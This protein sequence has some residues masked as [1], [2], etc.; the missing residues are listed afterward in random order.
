[1]SIKSQKTILNIFFFAFALIALSACSGGSS[2][3]GSAAPACDPATH[4]CDTTGIAK[5]GC[6]IATHDCETGALL[7]DT[8]TMMPPSPPAACEAINFC[9]ERVASVDTADPSNAGAD[10]IFVTAPAAGEAMAV[11]VTTDY[12]AY[13]PYTYSGAA[14][15][16][17]AANQERYTA[18]MDG[19]TVDQA[20]AKIQADAEYSRV[21]T[22]QDGI[23]LIGTAYAHARGYTG[24]R[25][26]TP[27][28]IVIAN[29]GRGI[30]VTSSTPE[31]NGDPISSVIE[32]ETPDLT[33]EGSV[34]ETRVGNLVTTVT[35]KKNPRKDMTRTTR[36]TRRQSLI[37]GYTANDPD[38]I[39]TPGACVICAT[40]G[41]VE[42]DDSSLVGIMSAQPGDGL[43][44]I[45]FD[46]S[47]KPVNI[48]AGDIY[49]AATPAN[50]AS[51]VLAIRE[52]SGA[53]AN[54]AECAAITDMAMKT[55]S[56]DCATI[57]VMNN[58]WDVASAITPDASFGVAVTVVNDINVEETHNFYYKLAN[59]MS[60]ISDVE[61]A[62]WVEAVET[63][64]VVFGAGDY[65]HNSENGIATLYED[66]NFETVARSVVTLTNSDAGFNDHMN[67]D[68][69]S[70]VGEMKDGIAWNLLDAENKNRASSHARL[71][72]EVASLK[73]KWLTV[74]AVNEPIDAGSG[75][76]TVNIAPFSNG[77]G[78]AMAWCLAAPGVDITTITAG[79]NLHKQ[80]SGTGI[81]AAH[82][83]GAIAVLKGAFDHLTPEQLVSV[84]LNTAD[85]LGTAGV[86]EVYGHG[87]LNLAAAIDPLG[88]AK[89]TDPS[90]KPIAR[91]ITLD[92]SGITLPTSFGES[93]DGFTVG[94]IDDYKRAY[95]GNPARIT[96]T[97]AAFTLGDTLATWDSPE[98]Q[99][100]QLDSNSKMQF[101]NYDESEHAK[102]T[103]IFTHH[104]PN[105][106]IAF[107][108][109]EEHKTPDL[110]LAGAGEELHFQK[111]RPIA[112][113]LMQVNSTHKLG[114]NLTVKNAITTGEFDTGNRFNEAMANLNYTS[115]NHQLTIGA[116][117]LQEYGQFLGASGTGAYQ[118]SD[119]TSSQIT[120]LAVTQNLPLNSAI[121]LKYTGFKTEV[122]MRY[123]NFATINDLTANEYQ[124][125]LTKKQLFGKSDSLNIELIQPF[126]VTDGKLQ[127]ST[128][129]GYN[130]DGD[131]NNVTQNYS[132][133]PTNRRQQIRMTWQNQLNHK[134][135]T[136]LFIS[137]Q[138]E[139][140]VNKPARQ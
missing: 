36:E 6:N 82:V 69:F 34:T 55:A 9:G 86:D 87:L 19:D 57:T 64:V 16:T 62:A 32:S 110:R 10:F 54:V 37:T 134:T 77:C 133:K 68:R 59:K 89:I 97:N 119:A 22:G 138:Y 47:I 74:V 106:T 58:G 109:N 120:H 116:G 114:K 53:D 20:V 29:L 100:I 1:M 88:E 13:V 78:D 31:L 21:D 92:N 42:K 33:V 76:M 8:D 115:E 26:T 111:I 136:K 23:D 90:L 129:L 107:S 94:F 108:Y 27:N 25:G 70:P 43:Q 81:A 40:R 14:A 125:S 49:K 67:K 123:D 61:A 65:G 15:D 132:L 99:S 98:L 30:G 117:S 118:L 63:T 85:D 71:P 28:S 3:G 72:L 44:G 93:L 124:L 60:T 24:K 80:R 113:D 35:V 95:I 12:Q 131:Y 127:Q 46:A 91:G 4:F 103:L 122:D 41:Q 105:H 121:K 96:R 104:L 135:K 39:V 50:R 52:A 102:D 66:E 11:D 83:S 101:S 5:A 79:N 51:L 17:Q 75:K 128:V 38:N 84:I 126:A 7:P 73:G 48:F 2:G 130:A 140:H 137:M 112:N 139:N 56:P 45:A 18:V